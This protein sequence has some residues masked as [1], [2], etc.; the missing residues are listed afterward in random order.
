[1]N[2][3]PMRV[4]VAEDESLTRRRLVRMLHGAGCIVAA[5]F[6]EGSETLRWLHHHH[7]VDA[8]FLDIQM[9]NLDGVTV[10]KSLRGRVPVVI[11]TA[12][13]EHAVTAFD[14]EAVDYLLKPF[15]AS[16]LRA[17]L[18]RLEARRHTA[19]QVAQPPQWSA[20]LRFRVHA[21]EGF[22]M[23]DLSKTS[24]FEVE[25]EVVWAFAGARL[26]TFWSSLIEVEEALPAAGLLRIHRRILLRPE[27]VLGIRPAP[28][29]RYAIRLG[30]GVEVEASRGGT[31]RLKERLGL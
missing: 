11:T 8:L 9:P 6:S 10:M 24:H 28:G 13:P 21:G 20:P 23:V 14:C 31:M 18:R 27:A 2:G 22:V 25:N 1:M 15:R 26:K 30:G 19:A 16:R 12:Y 17:A 29:S 5:E 4:V 7:D 3:M